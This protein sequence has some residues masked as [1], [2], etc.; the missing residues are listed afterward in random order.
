MPLTDALP[1]LFALTVSLLVLAFLSWQISLRTQLV[2]Y[3]LTRSADMAT[4]IIF[5]LFLPGVIVHELSHWISARAL[6]L[7]TSRFRV[8]PQQHGDHIGL[9]GV[10]V[11]RGGAWRDSIVGMAPLLTGTALIAWI[12]AQVFQSERLLVVLAQGRWLEG[13]GALVQ[14]MGNADGLV[15]AYLLFAVGNSMMPS[16]S[17]RQPVKALLLYLLF[18]A[19]IYVVVGLPI[20]PLNALLGWIVPAF[21]IVISALLFTIGV[22][23]FVL[24]VLLALELAFSRR[25]IFAGS[26]QGLDPRSAEDEHHQ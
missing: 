15:W 13:A 24:L 8:W 25:H 5:L 17:D 21:Q 4:V 12:G 3:Y 9:G 20:D 1:T 19:L 6:G 18:A 11:E 7:R 10:S 23:V 26:R 22:D 14:A 16:R 2:T